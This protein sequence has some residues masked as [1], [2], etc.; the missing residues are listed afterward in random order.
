MKF[1]FNFEGKIAVVT[2]AGSGIGEDIALKLAEEGAVVVVNGRNLDKINRVVRKIR[3]LGK[4]AL[5]LA[6]DV[7]KGNEVEAMFERVLETYGR[8]DFLVNNAGTN[9]PRPLVEME[10]EIW[11]QVMNINVKGAFLC[12]KAAARQMIKQKFGRIVNISSIAAQKT[13]YER[14]HYGAS[15]AALDSLTR[16]MAL[17]LARHN[18]RVNAV[19]PG[20]ILTPLSEGLLDPATREKYAQL[21]P[22]GRLGRVDEISYPVLFLLSEGSSFIT[23][24]VILVDGGLSI[25]VW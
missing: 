14:A 9:V 1:S 11:D 19:A 15:K 21:K 18:I 12:S 23:G 4:E 25:K 13:H 5:P 20:L 17:E 6:A 2:G 16:T 24:Q 7:S 22:M 8:V 10:E 3:D